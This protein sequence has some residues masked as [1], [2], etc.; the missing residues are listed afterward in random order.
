MKVLV[1]DDEYLQRELIKKAIDWNALGMEIGGEAED[2][3]EALQTALEVKPDIM[4]MDINIPY[5]NGLE[6][7]KKVK[8]VLPDT[9]VVILTA[10]GEFQYAREALAFGAVSFVLKPVNPEELTRELLKC[11]EKLEKIQGQEKSMRRM[12]EEI[13]QKQKEQFLLEQISGI[14]PPVKDRTVW[15]RLGI[16]FDCPTAVL[17]VKFHG[18]EGS[19]SREEEIEEMVQDYF[20][21]YEVLSIHRDVLFLL[22]GEKDMELCLQLLYTYLQEEMNR[23][24]VFSGGVS[25]VHIGVSGLR[26]AYQ[27]AYAAGKKGETKR[28]ICIFE[29]LSMSDFLSS[30]SYEPEKLMYLLRKKDYE[31]FQSSIGD[32]FNRMEGENTFLPAAYYVAMD[33]VVHFSLYLTELGIDFSGG[34]EEEQRALSRSGEN[35]NIQEMKEIL[36]QLLSRGQEMIESQRLPSTKKKVQDAKEFIDN[37]YHRFDMSLNLAA[38]AVGVNSSYLSNIFKKECGCSLSRYLTNVRLEHGKEWMK[39][40]PGMTLADIAEKVGYA[41]VYYFSK[42][43]KNYYGITPSKYQ[44]EIRK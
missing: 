25:L 9:Q 13:D 17:Y 43:F 34:T 23:K 37:N 20:P 22:F 40:E 31:T 26:E 42:T 41:D 35:G 1:V 38:E 33:I 4:I 3:E 15:E 30:V 19:D 10:Y 12:K 21:C 27:E 24:G 39:K 16:S 5:M 28:K 2:G 32:C 11:R 44:E 36:L 7:S 18:N 29:P 8:A 14:V 6:V